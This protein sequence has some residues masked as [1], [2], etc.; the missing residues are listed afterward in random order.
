MSLQKYL[1]KMILT[2]KTEQCKRL[3]IEIYLGEMLCSPYERGEFILSINEKLKQARLASGLTQEAVA[4]KVHVS[5]QT[6]SNWETGK[7]YPDIASLIVLSDVYEMTLDSLLKGDEKMIKHLKDSTD[8]AKSNKRL[9]LTMGI[10]IFLM[11]AMT[12]I[13]VFA[14]NVPLIS[15]LL[16]NIVIMVLFIFIMFSTVAQAVN[17]KGF[18]QKKTSNIVLFKMGVWVLYALFFMALVLLIP[19]TITNDFGVET[20]WIQAII[21]VVTAGALLIPAFAIHKKMG[22]LKADIRTE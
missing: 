9:T 3:L 5:R 19:E 2:P 12:L 13:N 21:R 11:V 18:L 10:S 22:R 20:R 1:R 7:T 15:G 14:P 17:V 8:V 16:S 4:E 6:I